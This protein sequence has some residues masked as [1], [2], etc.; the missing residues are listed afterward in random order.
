MDSHGVLLWVLHALSLS[1]SS[2]PF[3]CWILQN[4]VLQLEVEKDALEM[5]RDQTPSFTQVFS[6]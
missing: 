2:V 6:W 1:P 4:P 5:V 3:T